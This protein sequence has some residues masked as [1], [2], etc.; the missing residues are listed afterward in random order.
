MISLLTTIKDAVQVAF[1]LSFIEH[2]GRVLN[3]TIRRNI[4]SNWRGF[5]RPSVHKRQQLVI[6]L[7]K[8]VMQEQD[9]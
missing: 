4:S 8:T 6:N 9:E 7:H 1:A 3:V 5:Q 2:F